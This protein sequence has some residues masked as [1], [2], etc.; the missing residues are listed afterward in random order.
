MLDEV[1]EMPNIVSGGGAAAAVDAVR[2]VD[3]HV[4]TTLG[5]ALRGSI[6]VPVGMQVE[7]P[8][9]VATGAPPATTLTAPEVHWPVT[10]GGVDVPV[11]AQAVTA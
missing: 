8:A 10:H 6:G 9:M 3:I 2:E 11:S 7:E 4:A 5:C 1:A